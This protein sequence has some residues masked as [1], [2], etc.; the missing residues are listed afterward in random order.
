MKKPG[1][2]EH[3]AAGTE[4]SCRQRGQCGGSQREKT[5]QGRVL[6]SVAVGTHGNQQVLVST[7][8]KTDLMSQSQ[9]RYVERQTRQQQ[10]ED[11]DAGS[12][13]VYA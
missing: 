8:A 11:S 12:N 4:H 13:D 9:P 3:S 7:I 6:Q 1:E 2:G 10:R 5:K